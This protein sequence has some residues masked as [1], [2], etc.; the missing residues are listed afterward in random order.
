MRYLSYFLILPLAAFAADPPEQA[1]RGKELFNLKTSTGLACSTC[2]LLGGEGTAIGPDLKTFGRL[3]PRAVVI[4]I[5]A[6]RTQYVRAITPIKGT[7]FP[8]IQSGETYY[9]LSKTPPAP[10]KLSESDLKSA[11]DNGDWKHPPESRGLT[12]DQLADLIAYL[13]FATT[14]DTKGV[15][16]SDIP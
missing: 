1:K 13:R 5:L 10:V 9:D 16:P 3:A 6:T 14:G 8:V 4:G 11:K 7:T 12:K 15:S 2:H